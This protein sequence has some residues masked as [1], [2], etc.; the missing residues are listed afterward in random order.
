MDIV[1]VYLATEPVDVYSTTQP[2]DIVVYL[3]TEPVYVVVL[4]QHMTYWTNVDFV[5]M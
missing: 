4:I 1:V 2:M 5:V 3:A